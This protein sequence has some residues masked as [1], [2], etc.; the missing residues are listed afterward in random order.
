MSG[1]LTSLTSID[2][3]M[4]PIQQLASQMMVEERAIDNY[5]NVQRQSEGRE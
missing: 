5:I 3:Y 1:S 4:Q 2:Y